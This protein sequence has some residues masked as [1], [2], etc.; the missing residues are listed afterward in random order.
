M[1]LKVKADFKWAHEHVHVKEYVKGEE[2]ETE[3]EDLIRVAL[4]EGWAAKVGERAKAA[5]APAQS[6]KAAP[7]AAAEQAAGDVAQGQD[8]APADGAEGEGAADGAV[9]EG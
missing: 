7:E 5:A 9:T 2:F 1:N 3:D 4:E 8:A 6:A